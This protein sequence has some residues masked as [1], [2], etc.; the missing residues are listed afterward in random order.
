MISKAL[1]VG[2]AGGAPEFAS[3]LREM[4]ALSDDFRRLWRD[5]DVDDPGEGV[6]LYRSKRNGLRT[7]RHSTL[8]PE[9]APQLRIVVYLQAS[10]AEP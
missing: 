9:A 3:F 6:Y 8:V 4:L 7:F 10:G 2:Q 1:N 5:H